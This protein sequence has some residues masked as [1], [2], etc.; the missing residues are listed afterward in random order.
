MD[1]LGQ[2][3]E[4]GRFHRGQLLREHVG[5]DLDHLPS[6]RSTPASLRRTRSMAVGNTQFLNGAPLR[7]ASGLRARTGT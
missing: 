7:K 5:E 4:V 1:A 2:H 3:L 6:R